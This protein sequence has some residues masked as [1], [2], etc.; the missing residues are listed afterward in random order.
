MKFPV[1]LFA[2]VVLVFHAA[3]ASSW[4]SADV[5]DGWGL[6]DDLGADFSFGMNFSSHVS[7]RG[8][9]YS[10]YR[11]R[12]GYGYYTYADAAWN[13][14]DSRQV[15]E[16]AHGQD[17]E[18]LPAGLPPLRPRQHGSGAPTGSGDPERN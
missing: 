1:P 14:P 13:V 15:A 6:G 2:A 5:R 3:V 18:E 16:T 7:G 9:Y 12:N 10:D 17:G 8:R 4:G 11:A